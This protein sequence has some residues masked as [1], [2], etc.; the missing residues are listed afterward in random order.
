[1]TSG[2]STRERLLEA[3][4]TAIT[5]HGEAG[6]KVDAIADEAE[7]TKPSLYHFFGDRE[8]LIVAAQ[9]ERFRRSLRIGLDEAMTATRECASA[10]DFKELIRVFVAGFSTQE[11]GAERRRARMEVLG[12]TAARPA[13]RK[14]VNEVFADTANELAQLVNIARDRGWVTNS[15]SSHSIGVWWC[16]TLSGRYI[17]ESNDAFAND[18]WDNNLLSATL[19]LLF[20]ND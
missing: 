13:L 17:V 11:Q 12:A 19:H 20:D 8:G 18:E 15:R 7:I 6:V 14:V 2:L 10:D 1:M 3:T 9:A 16:V 5:I 4:I